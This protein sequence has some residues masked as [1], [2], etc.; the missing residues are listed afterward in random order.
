MFYGVDLLVCDC[1]GCILCDF[2][3]KFQKEYYCKCIDEYI[4]KLV[5]DCKF[6]DIE[7]FILYN[8]DYLLDIM[9]SGNWILVDI[10]KKYGICQIYEVVKL[11]VVIQVNILFLFIFYIIFY[12]FY[13]FFLY[14]YMDIDI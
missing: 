5:K 1:N 3:K 9:D 8:Y 14:I 10:V 13:I 12:L 6:E 4:I 7:K 2:V 11:M